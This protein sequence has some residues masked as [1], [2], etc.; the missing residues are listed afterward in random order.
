MLRFLA[1]ALAM[2][3]LVEV[4]SRSNEP[5]ERRTSKRKRL[6]GHRTGVKKTRWL[7]FTPFSPSLLGWP[8]RL[9]THCVAPPCRPHNLLSFRAKSGNC[10]FGHALPGVESDES[11]YH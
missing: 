1:G 10:H 7:A 11:R 5:R 8:W 9:N 3:P 6:A 2:T 4:P